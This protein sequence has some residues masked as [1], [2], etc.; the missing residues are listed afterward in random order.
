MCARRHPAG[1]VD[2]P[3]WNQVIRRARENNPKLKV[4][5]DPNNV[6]KLEEGLTKPE[7][8]LKLI[9]DNTVSDAIREELHHKRW[10]HRSVARSGLNW[11]ERII[12]FMPIPKLVKTKIHT[13]FEELRTEKP[14]SQSVSNKKSLDI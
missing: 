14:V 3:E 9:L 6:E 8:S 5:F 11:I 10:W 4:L 2:A 1:R 12:R 7:N 13:Y